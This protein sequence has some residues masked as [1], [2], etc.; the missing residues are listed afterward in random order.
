M[1][2]KYILAHD[3]GTGSDKAALVDTEANILEHKTSEYEVSY[4]EKGWAVQHPEECWWCAIEESTKEL[5]DETGVESSQVVGIVFSSQMAGTVPVDEDGEP[6]MSCMIWLDTR[7]SEQAEKIWSGPLQI[8]GYNVFNLVEFL[9]ITGGAPGLA[10]KDPI[11]K[12]LWLKENEPELY[13]KAYKILDTKDYL[14]HKCTNNFVTSEDNANLSWLMDSRTKEW[15]ERIC[16][17]YDID[18]EKLPEIKKSPDIAGELTAQSA[19]DLNLEVGTPVVVG[20]GD[21]TAAAIGS[22]AVTEY[23]THAY[24]GTSSW[25]ANHT[26]DRRKDIGHYVGSICSANPEM[27]LCTAEQENAGACLEWVKN[28]IFKQEVEAE[29]SGNLYELFDEMADEVGPGAGGLIFTPWLYG[30]RAPLDDHS[31]RGGFH[32]LS[33]EHTRKHVIRSVF[34]GVAFNLKWALKYV[35]KLTRKAESINLI[36]GGASSGIWCQIFADVLN[37]KINQVKKPREAGVR[38]AAMIAGVGLGYID[39]FEDIEDLVT[40][41]N[42]FEPDSENQETYGKLFEEFR[43]IYENNKEMY[44]RLNKTL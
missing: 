8:S 24:I 15:S 13:E 40:I 7:A 16:E 26:Y 32:N 6:L 11:C 27:Y 25:V 31:V 2:E 39:K 44:E 43:N 10:G 17:K 5:L 29:K 41:N 28:Q 4:P 3:V 30:E 19:E 23:K 9:W 33:L 36:G 20:A 38:G 21:V 14:I 12:I 1:S 18:I 34:E 37:R 42:T 35:E 22:G